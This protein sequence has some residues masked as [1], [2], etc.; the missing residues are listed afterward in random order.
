MAQIIQQR[1]TGAL[2]T[3][4]HINNNKQSSSVQEPAPSVRGIPS[5]A[6]AS[7]SGVNAK[8]DRARKKEQRAVREAKRQQC[9]VVATCSGHTPTHP[10][11]PFF[12]GSSIGAVP[13]SLRL[14]SRTSAQASTAASCTLTTQSLSAR[15]R[16]KSRHDDQ[17]P[18]VF[19]LLPKHRSSVCCNIPRQTNYSPSVRIISSRF[20]GNIST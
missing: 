8:K 9:V 14:W 5:P 2:V 10:T 16:A 15:A 17:P 11:C 20:A 4:A 7:S 6:K 1:C 3:D 13:L 18:Y 19:L 12:T